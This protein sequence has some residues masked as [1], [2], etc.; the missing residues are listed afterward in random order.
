MDLKCPGAGRVRQPV[1]ETFTCLNCGAEVEIWTHER[2][3][4]CGS[5]GKPVSR[6][7][8]SMS[9]VQWCQRAKECIGVERYN[10]LIS[11][12]IISEDTEEE[13]HIPERLREFMEECGLPVPGSDDQNS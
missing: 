11:E 9:C 10:K 12:G 4:R 6:E 1:P 13:V 7:M 2:M 3:R 8:D 5:C